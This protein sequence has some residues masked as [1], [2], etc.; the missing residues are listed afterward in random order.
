[1]EVPQ[2]MIISV[3]VVVVALVMLSV[4]FPDLMK[5]AVAERQSKND[6]VVT[7]SSAPQITM[8]K[9]GS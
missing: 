8:N 1:M 6:V 4:L 9:T 2:E 5:T 3:I 7:L